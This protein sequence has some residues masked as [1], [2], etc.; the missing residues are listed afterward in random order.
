MVSP[1]PPRAL[2]RDARICCVTCCVSRTSLL[3]VIRA[4]A[5]RRA[6]VLSR[7]NAY[8]KHVLLPGASRAEQH[9]AFAVFFPNSGLLAAL[10]VLPRRLHQTPVCSELSNCNSSTNAE[11][12]INNFIVSPPK[13]LR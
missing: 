10:Q 5:I 1:G 4:G 11:F 12:E 13:N 6:F 8:T 7:G 2:N 3:G 9:A